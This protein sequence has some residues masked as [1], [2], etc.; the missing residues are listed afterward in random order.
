MTWAERELF[1]LTRDGAA[2]PWRATF[3]R[4]GGGEVVEANGMDLVILLGDLLE[5]NEGY[6][7]RVVLASLVGVRSS[8]SPTNRR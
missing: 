2:F 6:F 5:R 4:P 7:D 1:E 3:G 8:R